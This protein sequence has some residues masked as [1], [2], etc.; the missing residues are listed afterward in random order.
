MSRTFRSLAIAASTAAIVAAAPSGASAATAPGGTSIKA[1]PGGGFQVCAWWGGWNSCATVSWANGL[2]AGAAAGGNGTSA[3]AGAGVGTDGASAS[4]DASAWGNGAG[5][6]AGIAP[7]YAR[8]VKSDATSA[9]VIW[10][11]PTT[12]P[13]ATGY[14]VVTSD[15]RKMFTKDRFL[16]LTGLLPGKAYKALVMA[17]DGTNNSKPIEINFT[18]PTA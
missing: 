3:S 10:G 9:I 13:T 15:G 1:L 5:A 8:I 16:P 11:A 6:Y 12:G 7:A 17:T 18:T 2:T 4:A 14:Y